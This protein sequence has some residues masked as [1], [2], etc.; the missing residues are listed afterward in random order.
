MVTI[1][2]N[3]R[4]KAGKEFI[5]LALELAKHSNSIE[6]EDFESKV[7]GE[8]IDQG[9]KSGKVEKQKVD[10]MLAKVLK[11]Q[12]SRFVKDSRKN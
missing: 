1:R 10:K 12:K 6:I 8:M 7:L 2:V 5:K 11:P 9:M 4:T 3:E